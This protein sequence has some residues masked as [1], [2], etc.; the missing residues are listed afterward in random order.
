MKKK[1]KKKKPHLE[2]YTYSRRRD[3]TGAHVFATAQHGT[4]TTMLA[5][6]AALTVTTHAGYLTPQSSSS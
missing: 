6:R 1:K 4:Y 3:P 5:A 2:A